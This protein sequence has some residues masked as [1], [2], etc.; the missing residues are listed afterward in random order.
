MLTVDVLH[1]IIR[2]YAWGAEKIEQTLK[3]GFE[4]KVH[5]GVNFFDSGFSLLLH[6]YLIIQS[7]K[8]YIAGKIL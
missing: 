2:Q 3:S 7:Y 1:I 6:F 8:I 5:Y 4:M